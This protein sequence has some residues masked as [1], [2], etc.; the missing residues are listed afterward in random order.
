MVLW[1]GIEIPIWGCF[2]S[3]EGNNI[4][5]HQIYCNYSRL[6]SISTSVRPHNITIIRVCSSITRVRKSS[7]LYKQLG[8]IIVMTSK[9]DIL[10]VKTYWNVKIGPDAWQ[11]Q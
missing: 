4:K 11:G 1:L 9:T 5:C 8:N 10:I 6:I 3:E 2:A 7:N